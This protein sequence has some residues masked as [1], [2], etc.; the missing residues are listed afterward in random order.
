M[1]SENAKLDASEL[2]FI[3]FDEVHKIQSEAIL[4]RYGEDARWFVDAPEHAT[5]IVE[6]WLDAK[7]DEKEVPVSMD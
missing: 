5:T 2:V 4:A 1:K 3:A 6:Q 7:N